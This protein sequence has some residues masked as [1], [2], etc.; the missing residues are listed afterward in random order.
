MNNKLFAYS[1]TVNFGQNW[2][3][4]NINLGKNFGILSENTFQKAVD[5]ENNHA[6]FS[7]FETSD[8][9]VSW[10][11]SHGNNAEEHGFVT[12]KNEFDAQKKLFKHF[13]INGNYAKDTH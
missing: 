2:D 3:D 10:H 12:A 6:V 11:N 7:E 5:T 1:K 4:I 8:V 9:V 13:K